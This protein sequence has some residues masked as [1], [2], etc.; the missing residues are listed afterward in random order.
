[1]PA[2]EIIKGENGRVVIEGEDSGEVPC[3]TSWTLE[4][5][6]SLNERNNRC[7]KSNDDNTGSQWA[8]QTLE[9]RAFSLELE[10]FWQESEAIPASQQLDGTHVGSMID[11]IVYPDDAPGV[12]YEGRAI[13]DSVSLTGEVNGDIACSVSLTGDGP[14]QVYA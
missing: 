5:S 8:A 10:F 6:A 14:L 13:I 12:R 11:F 9:G 4:A 7:M 2:G 3:L 1:M